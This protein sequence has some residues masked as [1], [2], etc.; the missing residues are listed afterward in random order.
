MAVLKGV[1]EIRDEQ[2]G[3]LEAL[4]GLFA[5]ALRCAKAADGTGTQ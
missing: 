4:K 3:H 2:I 5:E 1:L